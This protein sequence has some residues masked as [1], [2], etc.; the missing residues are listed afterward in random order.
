[1][2]KKL[3]NLLGLEQE[4]CFEDPENF[5]KLLEILYLND[6]YISFSSM[7]KIWFGHAYSIVDKKTSLIKD[8][9]GA[10]TDYLEKNIDSRYKI[11]KKFKQQ[12]EQT[13]WK[14]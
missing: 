12:V 8:F 6:W 4:V 13:E 14:W 11:F 5:V 9:I 2:N 1:M 10:L 3:S 7:Q